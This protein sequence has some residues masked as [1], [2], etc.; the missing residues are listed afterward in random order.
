MK[1]T[2]F[3]ALFIVLTFSIMA[4]NNAKWIVK[5]CIG[6][7]IA[8]TN[9]VSAKTIHDFAI[10]DI[11]DGGN[12][13]AQL[14]VGKNIY[15]WIGLML[16]AN[17]SMSKVGQ[18][19]G[20]LFQ[21]GTYKYD[22]NAEYPNQIVRSKIFDFSGYGGRLNQYYTSLY[23][24]VNIIEKIQLRPSV[25][26][27]ISTLSLPSEYFLVKDPMSNYAQE[28]NY[29]GESSIFPALFCGIAL[30]YRLFKN[31]GATIN[32]TFTNSTAAI[33]YHLDKKD[34]YGNAT[35]ERIEKDMQVYPQYVTVGLFVKL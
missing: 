23:G 24:T 34:I 19:P 27:G 26:I 3:T 35:T 6:G 2:G 15:K 20:I 9:S 13:V 11:N 4:Q 10:A 29:R 18:Y 17:L 12:G 5:A 8:R 21:E 25:G 31:I 14:Q 28:I 33:A 16:H 1:K 32:Y 22:F 7:A 30:E